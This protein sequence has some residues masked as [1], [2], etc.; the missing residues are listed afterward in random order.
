MKKKPRIGFLW[1]GIDKFLGT[2]FKDGLWLALEHMKED[3]DIGYFEP[4][5]K[6]KIDLFKPDV[7]LFWGAL[8][9][10]SKPLVESYPYK[11]AICFA[12]GPIEQNNVD[13]F[14]MYF[15]ESDINRLEFEALGKPNMRAFG[16]NDQIYRPERRKKVFDAMFAGTFAAWKRPGLFAEAVGNKGFWAGIHQEHEMWCV[17]V[18]HEHGVTVSDET[19]REQIASFL[20]SSYSALNTASFWGGGQRMTLEAMACNIPPIVMSDSPKNVELVEDAGYGIICEPNVSSI[21][22]A[23]A[24]A[25]R[26]KKHIGRK[27]IESKW[28]SK[29]YAQN[30]KE[31]LLNIL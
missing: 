5:H 2:R 27:Y 26:M 13:G 9:E 24:K 3:F 31:G 8:I 21:R 19:S 15:Y 28:T 10:N 20:N 17:D 29:H 25:K 11:K 30:L 16:V 23:V 6:Q 18:C 12:G 14:D 7:L 1:D 22:R 4:H